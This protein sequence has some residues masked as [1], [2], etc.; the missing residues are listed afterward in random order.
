VVESRGD[1]PQHRRTGERRCD[2]S[3]PQIALCSGKQILALAFAEETCLE[4]LRKIGGW[5]YRGKIS[6]E[7]KCAA[8]LCITLCAALAFSNMS[9]H[10]NELDTG[11]GIVYERDVLI[12]KLT[13]VHEGRLEVR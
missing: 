11:E 8:N 7:K 1:V 10:A 5:L 12:T 9:L 3:A 6:K 2:R 13:T 4:P